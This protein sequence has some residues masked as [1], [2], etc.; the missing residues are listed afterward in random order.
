M[1]KIIE[2]NPEFRANVEA[3]NGYCPCGIWQNE[4]TKCMCKAFR[5]R[6][7]PGECF[8]GRFEKVEEHNVKAERD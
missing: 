4:D 2:I 7:E 3:N 5:E 6:T 1:L 8:C